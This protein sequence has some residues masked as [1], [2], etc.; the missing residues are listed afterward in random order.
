MTSPELRCDH[1]AATFVAEGPQAALFARSRAKG[2]RFLM[3]D[4]PH[5]LHG[6]AVD[7]AAPGQPRAAPR[8]PELPE[9][10]CPARACTGV[11]C[12]VD[13]LAPPLWGC[14]SC[15]DTWPDRATLD[16]AIAAAIARF[17]WRAGAYVRAADG[18]RAAA[19]LPARYPDDVATEWA[20]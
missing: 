1:C 4:C 20:A 12:F 7:P 9:L 16:A 5:C 2:M 11:A 14:G 17:P 18:Y 15:G 10:P 6:T 19:P 13:T 3:L 8:L